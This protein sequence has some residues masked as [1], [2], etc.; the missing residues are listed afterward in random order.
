VETV[1][2]GGNVTGTIGE[3][4]EDG[5]GKRGKKHV[6]ST[7][8][9]TV[10]IYDASGKLVA[11]YSTTVAQVS[12]AEVSYLTNDHLG[13]PRITTDKDGDVISRRDFMPF[14]EEVTAYHTAERSVGLN[15]EDDKVRQKFTGYERDDET[16]LDFA[17]ARYFNNGHGRFTTTDP[18]TLTVERLTDP[19][20]INLYAYCRNSPYTFIDPTGEIIS[21]ANKE[22]QKK[23]DEYV[24]FLNKD[25]EKYKSELATID[26]LKDS[27]VEYQLAVGGKDFEGAEGNLTTDGNKVFVSISN[28]GGPNGETF[29]LNSRFSH[30]LEHARQFD[31]GEL[32]FIKDEDGKWHPNSNVYDIGDEVKAWKAQ[33]NTSI[34]SDYWKTEGDQRKPSLLRDFADAK[35]DDERAGV[36]ARSSYPNRNPR[37]NSDFVYAGDKDYKPGQLI[38][39]D[40][41]FGRINRIA[42]RPK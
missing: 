38:R 21:F 30:E 11:E 6:P 32:T 4:W 26:R 34:A 5:D 27:E 17:Q 35:T 7:G 16:E 19:Q 12:E 3:C 18:V 13:S 15:Y 42:Q 14:G 29:S 25:K 39:T 23:F 31:N 10:F 22:A 40:N 9:T 8:E 37:Q 41:S 33:Q 28:V 1:D 36:L 20:R 2:A 24:E